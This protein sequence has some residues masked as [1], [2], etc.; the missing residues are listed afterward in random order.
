MP[1]IVILGAG[2][3]AVPTIR[4]TM[5][6]VVLKNKDYNMIVVAPNT[7]FLWPIAMPRVI[8][9]GQMSEDK[10]MVP[11]EAHF[12]E[13]P[14]EVFQFVLGKAINLDPEGNIV[15]VQVSSGESRD[16]SYDTLVVATGASS[17][18]G[19][20]WKIVESTQKTKEKIFKLRGDIERAQTI[21]V[22]GGG[23]TGSETAGELGFEYSKHGKKEVYLVHNGSYP[24]SPEMLESARKQAKVELEN[25][26]VKLIPHT[27]VTK[28]TVEGE[29][30]ILEL[31]SA[32]GT[33]RTLT[34]QAYIP[35]TGVTPNTA[36][37]PTSM[38][39]SRG[40]IKQTKTLNA[41]GYANVF[42]LGDVGSLEASKSQ[43]ADAQCVHL[44]RA[45][46]DHLLKGTPIPEYKLDTKD[47][48]AVTLG[49]S[50]ATGQMGG[51]KLPS[52]LIWFVKGRSLFTDM[53]EGWA[54]GRKTSSAVFEK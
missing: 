48:Y 26:N 18:D 2:L 54:A 11:L 6:N 49:R 12:N 45:L 50:K 3:A 25:L 16:I 10:V 19:M 38:V 23:A 46:P 21:V 22:A 29:N 30:T 31:T 9:P 32:D 13:Y 42:V 39:N 36:F 20:P 27:T 33:T 44:I 37:A 53:V 34:T 43:L 40:Y 51:W 4:Q 24:L 5:R 52:F 15:T 1:T 14:A 17:R 47:V 7:H 28:V 35:A 8:V 41:E